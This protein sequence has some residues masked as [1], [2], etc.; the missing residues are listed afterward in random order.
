MAN[1]KINFSEETG[2]IKPIHGVGQPPFIGTDYSK[3]SFLREANIPF[4]RLHDV[5]YP[6][7]GNRY[8]DIPNLFRDFSADPHDPESYDFAFTD[9]LISALMENGVEPF[10]RLGVTIENDAATK[11]YRIFPPKD[12]KKWAEICEGV[13]RH[14][15]EGWADGFNYDIRYWEIW[16]EPDNFEDPME[17]QMWRGSK[18]QFYELYDVT[19]RHLKEKFPHLKIG[20]YGSCGFYALDGKGAAVA[21]SSPRFEY[22]ISFFDGFIDYIKEHGSPLDFFSWHSYADVES[23]MCHARYAR[24]RLDEAGFTETEH[25]CNEWNLCPDIRGT[26]RHAA[27]N[28]AMLLAM[29]NSSLDS[30]MFYDAQLGVNIY[31]GLFDPL[32]HT[33][34]PLY[35]GFHSFGKLYRLGTQVAAE[36]DKGGVYAV[37]ATDGETGGILIANIGDAT[38][39]SLNIENGAAVK[40]RIT[41]ETRTNEE[42]LLPDILPE[43]S[44]LYV[45]ICIK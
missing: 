25:T 23:T 4:S 38:H 13:I 3:F 5:E 18:E 20:G 15:T 44:V 31:G 21:N 7:G 14:Y 26:A 42:C 22:F 35:Y 34:F 12:P 2:E 33:P 16:N 30:S 40:C 24:R 11:A 10:F 41:D 37:A 43:N 28:T 39:L 17:N 45:E 1:I 36:C 6:Y 27:L 32:H 19:A 29:Q 8:V 9:K